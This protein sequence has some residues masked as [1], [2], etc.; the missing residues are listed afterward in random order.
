VGKCAD[1]PK[2]TYTYGQIGIGTCLAGPADLGFY[3]SDGQ[4]WLAVTNANPYLT[5]DGGSLLLIDW[6]S[7]DLDAD[8][9][10]VAKLE[11]HAIE[12]P[13]YVGGLGILQD[14]EQAIVTSRLSEGAVNKVANDLAYVV[15]LSNPTKPRL[16]R[17]QQTVSLRDDP[18]PVVVD[19]TEQLTYIGNLTDHSVAIIDQS[20]KR[21]QRIDVAPGTTVS[22]AF[23]VDTDSSGTVA[24]VGEISVD[25]P[26][27]LSNDLWTLT[28]VDG[29]SRIWLPAL[30]ERDELGLTRWSSGGLGYTPSALGVEVDPAFINQ[31]PDVSDPYLVLADGLPLMFFASSN[32][33]V[34]MPSLGAIGDW[35]TSS[36]TVVM[37]G[38]RAWDATV[39]SPSVAAAAGRE[40]LYYEG[41]DDDGV[42]S[43][44]IAFTDDG[45]NWV[46]VDTPVI[47]PAEVLDEDGAQRFLTIE[48]PY[49]RADALANQLRMWVS[50]YDGAQWTIGLTESDA[51]DG[52]GWSPIEEVLSLPGE[53]VAAPVI[54]YMNNR[55]IMW[56]VRSDGASWTHTSAWSYDGREWFDLTE[57]AESEGPY[58]PLAPPRAGVQVDSTGQW[59]LDGRDNGPF[60]ALVGE[61]SRFIAVSSGFSIVIASGQEV[62]NNVVPSHRAQQGLIPGSL[63]DVDGED[64]LY[65]TEIGDDSRSR[66]GALRRNGDSWQIVDSDLIPAGT[67]GNISGVTH[68]VVHEQDGVYT[69]FY[70][71][72]SRDS[73]TTI[74]RATSADGFDFTTESGHVVKSDEDWDAAAQLPHDVEVMDN[75]RIRL[76]YG[77]SNGSRFNIGAATAAAPHRRFTLDPGVFEP[78]QFG[79][80]IPGGFDDSSVKDPVLYTDED[81]LRHLYYAGFDGLFWHLGHAV[82]DQNGGW[83]RRADP[84]TD[85]SIASTGGVANTFSAQGIESPVITVNDDGSLDVLYA[86]NDGFTQRLGRAVGNGD[87]ILYPTQRFGTAED[88]FTFT[89]RQGR[90]GHSVIELAQEVESFI[91]LGIGMSD[92]VLDED[93]GFLYVPSKLATFIYVIDV[94]DD[95]TGVFDDFNYRD[96]EGLV[97]IETELGALG[98]HGALVD[99]ARDRLYLT[100]RNPDGI[101]IVDLTMLED[102]NVKE[103]TNYVTPAALSLPSLAVDEGGDTLGLIGGAGM[104]L[105]ADGRYLLA[106]HFRDN[107]LIAFDLE[108]GAYGEEVRYIQHIGENPHIVQ[109][110]PDGRYAVVANYVGDLI[111]ETAHST[112]AIVDADPSSTTFLEVL[113]WIGNL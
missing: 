99:A 11:S 26:A 93:R 10:N 108:M 111:D 19:D 52:F 53:D 84:T 31:V 28:F 70:G 68:P 24:E 79:T 90:V 32:G 25:F 46:P 4:T 21:L 95:S 8:F 74:R 102:N 38:S 30:T 12:L 91:T 67:G 13:A 62:L 14:R 35:D 86:G 6:D 65:V 2:G 83:T 49:V 36:A 50:L 37:T 98:F 106:T 109:L 64:I 42:S 48:D 100:S 45:L 58:D 110:T 97:R 73:I 15:D 94:R 103:T 55:Y 101:A 29:L 113:T 7:I 66:I 60:E 105:T 61:G 39:H 78:F 75:G 27:N 5:F 43:V 57:I 3:E 33:I 47:D 9:N 76:W 40:A 112:L 23:F 56:F 18:Q 85:Q 96:L 16:E 77:G 81:G 54:K 34:N 71:A 51:S 17:K 104:T 88:G 1:N 41:R 82:D 80:G 22:E 44:G 20:G 72:I 92:M 69:M 59:R 87:G 107:A 89:T 63:I